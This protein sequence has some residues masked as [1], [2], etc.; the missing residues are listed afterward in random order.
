MRVLL[1]SNTFPPADISGVGTLVAELARQLRAAGHEA[2]ALV[3]EAPSQ[4]GVVAVGGRKLFFPWSAARAV[5]RAAEGRPFDVIHVHESDGV[6]VVLRQRLARLFGRAAGKARLVATLQVSYRR[7]RWAVRPVTAC[8][9]VVSRPARSEWIF[10]W[11]RAPFHALLGRITVRLADAVVAPSAATARELEEDYGARSVAVIPNGIAPSDALT[12]GG[13][14]RGKTAETVLFVGRLRTRKAVAVL[15][16]AFAAVVRERPQARLVLL[17]DGEQRAALEAQIAR[18]G[19][20]AAVDLAGAVPRAATAD[21]LRRADVFCLPSTYEGFPLAILE[22]MAE[23]LPVVATRVAG[24]PEAVEDGASGLLVVPEDDRALATALLALLGD[25]ERRRA[26]G[27][28]GRALLAERFAIDAV[29][30][31]HLELF[32]RLGNT[33]GPGLARDPAERR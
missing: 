19:L 6:L 20:G 4:P 16:E 33:G 17:G 22:A 9:R 25:P 5:R 31:R 1:V 27:A 14:V 12:S 10:R 32:A 8:G 15:V 13:E 26:F 3:R 11:F 18:L 24:V 23:G 7:E 2:V 30:A 28:R 29:C 21:W